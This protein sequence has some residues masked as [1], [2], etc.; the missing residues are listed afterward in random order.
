MLPF[1]K[2][3]FPVDYS[4]PC[5]TIVP[6]VQEM[7]RHF[8]A[9]LTLVHAYGP[10]T[11]G[12]SGLSITD[13]ELLEKAQILEEQRL[14]E[15]A[16]DIFPGQ[17]VD[18]IV[19]LGEPGSIIDKVV[20]HQGADLVM[21]ST[22]GR[23]PIRRFL[24]GSVAA[25]V[26]H[27]VSAAVWTGVGSVFTGHTPKIPYK[28]ILCALDE[29]EEAAAVLKAA[30]AIASSYNAQMTIVHVLE[31]PASLDV[32]FSSYRKLMMDAADVKLRELKGELAV[33]APHAV[34]DAK[35]PEGVR[36]EALR[37]NA[38]LIITGRGRAQTAFNSM[39]SRLY[40][41]VRE[42]PCPVLSI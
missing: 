12:L 25:K 14:R 7:I 6:Y 21:L 11:V 32:D 23:G 10:A 2:I 29:S 39:W 31:V 41:T 22:H 8:A 30:A 37:R 9:D 34:I 33:D 27:D 18:S 1:R 15:F 42:S 3:L 38:D 20:Q 13:P 5:Q 40:P 17:H 16:R 4:E 19:E 36:Q 28:S 24:L 35:V 26:L